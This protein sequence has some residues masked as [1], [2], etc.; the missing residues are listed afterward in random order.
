MGGYSTGKIPSLEFD[1]EGIGFSKAAGSSAYTP[2]F[3]TALPPVVLKAHV[4]Q[5]GTEVFCDSVTLKFDNDL[6]W[7][8]STA[9]VGGR[10][11]GRVAGTRKITG[12]FNPYMDDTSVANWTTFLAGSNFSMFITATVADPNNVGQF[13]MGSNWGIYLPN[14]MLTKEDV[15][16]M[17]GVLT[18]ALAFEANGGPQGILQEIFLGLC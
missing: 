17:K 1:F 14:V 10:F 15:G 4:F 3:D 13:V 12:T 11:K 5:G 7:M 6:G 8:T 2:T 9:F 18:D 16:D